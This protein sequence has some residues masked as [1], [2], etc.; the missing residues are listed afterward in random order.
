[1]YQSEVY[2]IQKACESLNEKGVTGKKITIFV[3]NQ[4][5]ITS[6]Y[7]YVVRNSIVRDAKMAV[8]R[9]CEQNEVKIQWIPAHVGHAGNEIADRLAKRGAANRENLP[10]HFLP[11]PI[12]EVYN[13]I[14]RWGKN[15]HQIGWDNVETCRQTKMFCPQTSNKYWKLISSMNRRNSMYITQIFTG[16]A[17][18]QY[19]LHKMKIEQTALCQF[20]KEEDETI[21]HFIAKCP[22]FASKRRQVFIDSFIRVPMHCIHPYAI[23]KFVN[24]TKRFASF[25]FKV[26]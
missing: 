7:N 20:C 8:N 22:Y 4:A 3:D 16:H 1:M 13:K 12:Q 14:D 5:A 19:H 25:N 15:Q 6:I 18:V 23:M 11:V 9:I 2:A 10:E 17:S 26:S 21:E 24:L